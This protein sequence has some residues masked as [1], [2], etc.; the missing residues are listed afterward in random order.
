MTKFSTFRASALLLAFVLLPFSAAAQSVEVRRPYRGLFGGDPNDRT[1]SSFSVELMGAYDDNVYGGTGKN[2]PP[3]A[4]QQSGVFTGVSATLT[5]QRAG[6]KFSTG[7]SGTSDLRYYAADEFT[8]VAH[9]LNAFTGFRLSQRTNVRLFGGVGYSPLYTPIFMMAPTGESVT[10]DGVTN[11]GA[12]LS[13]SGASGDY[14]IV[15]RASLSYRGSFNISQAVTSRTSIDARYTARY[16]DFTDTD[17]TQRFDTVAVSGGYRLSRY[18]SFR[19]GYGLNSYRMNNGAPTERYH[20][21]VLGIDYSRPLSLSGRRT[22]FTVTPGFALV[23]NNDSGLQL[24]LAGS[25]KLD[26]EIGRTWTAKAL[27]SR[28]VRFVEGADTEVLANTVQAGV[29]GLIGRR[30]QLSVE[31]HM[32]LSDEEENARDYRATAGSARLNYAISR[33]L[34]AYGQ[35]IYYNYRF[36]EAVVLPVTQ[37]G[38]TSRQGVRVGIT[39]WTPVL[40]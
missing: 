33:R 7:L 17:E 1:A 40:Q 32:V 20:D 37:S 36:G 5:L 9:H 27:Y 13:G 2:P 12:A 25:A 11:A 19:A 3:T 30:F 29:H 34:S 22:R 35:Y 15:E 4:A 26:H 18:S 14:A 39:L 38:R 31:G 28:G 6:E 10:P 8:A 16:V 24:R 21:F 23:N